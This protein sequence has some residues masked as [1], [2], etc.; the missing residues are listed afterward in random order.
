MEGLKAP[1]VM[2]RTK[3]ALFPIRLALLTAGLHAQTPPEDL[4]HASLET[5]MNTQVTSV[6]KK[7]ETLSQT[8]AAVFVITQDAYRVGP[9]RYQ[10]VPAYPRLDAG[11]GWRVGESLGLRAGLQNLLDARHWEFVSTLGGRLP[12]QSKRGAYAKLTWQF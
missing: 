7:A 5:L 1:L 6:S 10:G 8:A 12:T 3:L 2:P 9:L 11:L 4:S